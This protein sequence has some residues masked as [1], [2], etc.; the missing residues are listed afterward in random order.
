M[1]WIE[2]LEL[3]IDF[4]LTTTMRNAALAASTGHASK[5][6]AERFGRYSGESIF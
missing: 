5:R 6:R 3:V 4:T 1:L 2:V